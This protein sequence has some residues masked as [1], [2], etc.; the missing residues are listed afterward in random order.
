M[1]RHKPPGRRNDTNFVILYTNARDENKI[2][3]WIAHHLLLG[4]DKIIIFD[5]L[6]KIPIKKLLNNVFGNKV[7]IIRVSGKG[8]IKIPLMKKAVEISKILNASWML[9]LDADEFLYLKYALNVKQM[10]NRFYF[11]DQLAINWLMFG[12]SNHITQP[13]G[14]LTENFTRSCKMINHH[15]KVFVRPNQVIDTINPHWYNIYDNNR[16]IYN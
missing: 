5:H 15:I 4:F 16:F 6:S 2:P 9:Y 10:L 13:K 1:F 12:T 14:L 8:N 11:A 3:E 7:E